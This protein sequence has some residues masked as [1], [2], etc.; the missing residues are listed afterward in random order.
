V[1]ELLGKLA[2][3]LSERYY[4]KFRGFVSDNDDPQKRARLRLRVPSVLGEAITDWALPCLPFG[5]GAGYG[6]FAVPEKEAQ[7]WVEFEEGDL[8][9]P[10]WVGAFWQR[11]EDVPANAAQSPPTTRLFATPGGHRLEFNDQQ[12]SETLTLS[13]PKKAS[14][15]IDKDGAVALT[16]AQGARLFLDAAGERVILEDS[17]G[18]TLTMSSS[19][20]LIEDSHGNKI[21]MS[22]AGIHLK[23]QQ[24]AVEGS[25][26]MLG[27]QGGEPL[28]KGTS[29]LR[30]FATHTHPTAM[31]PSGPPIPQGEATALSTKVMTS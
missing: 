20:A 30:L 15:T 11:A 13:H 27:G 18:N 3:Q 19:G 31:G 26:V 23:G 28:L 1:E 9:R 8:H 4:G 17:A 21:E 5:G 12:D 10:L 7:V 29:F 14:L 6:W 24:I 25:Q 16:D 22:G 2:R